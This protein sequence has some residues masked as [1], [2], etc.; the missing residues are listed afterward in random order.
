MLTNN[1]ILQIQSAI[2]HNSAGLRKVP[3]TLL[4][5]NK[6]E[7]VYTPPQHPQD[8]VD[9]MGN[10]E[11]FINDPS[12]SDWDPLTKMAVIHHQF[13]SIHPFYDGNGRTG[14]VINIL[15]L[16]LQGLLDSPILYLSRFINQNKEKYYTLLQQTRTT[17]QWESWILFILEGVELTAKSTTQLVKDMRELM[18]EYKQLMKKELPKIYS[19][20]LL[21]NLFKHPYTKIEFIQE[22]LQV[23]RQTAS[24]YLNALVAVGLLSKEKV[25]TA[26]FYLNHALFEL[27]QTM[28][29][30][31]K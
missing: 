4:K 28:S 11:Q 7:T 30:E 23:S 13:E 27:L 14:R 1:D 18:G 10:L 8:I 9:L 5:N 25:G 26:H 3:G 6:G 31:K 2:E 22:D 17:N 12:L 24:R 15:Y 21:N 19:Q 20:E 29:G 16:V